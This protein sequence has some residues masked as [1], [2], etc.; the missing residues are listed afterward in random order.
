MNLYFIQENTSTKLAA[1]E[2]LVLTEEE[3]QQERRAR[4]NKICVQIAIHAN[5]CVQSDCDRVRCRKMKRLVQHVKG[6]RV[7]F[8]SEEETMIFP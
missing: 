6:C 3:R 5:Q 1:G 2:S 7:C 8:S 4:I